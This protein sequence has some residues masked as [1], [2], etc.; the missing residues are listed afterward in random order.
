MKNIVLFFAAFL[1]TH[2]SIAQSSQIRISRYTVPPD[3]SVEK[4]LVLKM[5]YGNY[6]I[7]A[8]TGD[9]VAFKNAGEIMVDVICTD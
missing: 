7:E 2:A 8:I 5:P 1:F 4:V 3:N 9:T 6:S